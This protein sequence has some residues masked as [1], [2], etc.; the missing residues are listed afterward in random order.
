MCYGLFFFFFFFF[1]LLTYIL[2]SYIT[3]DM[4]HRVRSRRDMSAGTSVPMEMGVTPSWHMDVFTNLEV[5]Q[6]PLVW[7]LDFQGPTWKD[8]MLRKRRLKV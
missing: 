5:L 6:S 4:I 8:G 7:D 2:V 3:E 1:F